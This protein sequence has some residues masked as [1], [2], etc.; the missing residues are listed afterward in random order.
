MIQEIIAAPLTFWVVYFL[1]SLIASGQIYGQAEK[2][3]KAQEE[4][5]AQSGNEEV[6]EAR[7]EVWL[8]ELVTAI[9][10]LVS[11]VG[12]IYQLVKVIT[13]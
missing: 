7:A 2:L 12:L 9:S 11:A 8:P 3:R 13:S 5:Y 6:L 4:A 1:L 10:L